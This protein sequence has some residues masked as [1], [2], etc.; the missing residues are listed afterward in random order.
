MVT[1]CAVTQGQLAVCPDELDTSGE[2]DLPEVELD[3]RVD[4]V[5][6]LDP[7][8][9][10]ASSKDAARFNARILKQVVKIPFKL[11][12]VAFILRAFRTES[13]PD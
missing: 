9:S 6:D 3:D 1:P 7:A 4:P 13:F 8:R 2:L 10:K 5:L 11:Q 12:R